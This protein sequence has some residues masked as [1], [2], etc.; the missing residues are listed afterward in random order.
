M[1]DTELGYD[2]RDDKTETHGGMDVDEFVSLAIDALQNDE[3]EAAIGFAA[4]LRA[5]PGKCLTH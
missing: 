3:Y 2:H 5:N 4:G 1:V